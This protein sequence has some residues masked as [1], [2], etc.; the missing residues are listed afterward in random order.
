MDLVKES[1]KFST[2]HNWAYYIEVFVLY[3]FEV[4]ETGY[5]WE[6]YIGRQVEDSS[7]ITP[8]DPISPYFAISKFI[9]NFYDGDFAIFG[10]LKVVWDCSV[11]VGRNQSILMQGVASP[12]SNHPLLKKFG[13]RATANLGLIVV[14]S[15]QFYAVGNEARTKDPVT[16]RDTVRHELTSH[17]NYSTCSCTASSRIRRPQ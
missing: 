2:R 11:R 15:Y 13:E 1:L 8:G 16:T 12:S 7:F 5:N 9:W 4:F 6:D 14:S 3:R 10:N 17:N